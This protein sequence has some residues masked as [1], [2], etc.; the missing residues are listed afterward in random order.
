MSKSSKECQDPRGQPL[1]EL[2]GTGEVK[3]EVTRH[4]GESGDSRVDSSQE[5]KYT[6]K[7]ASAQGGRVER[8]K[9]D[10]KERVKVCL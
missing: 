6:G 1:E 7:G 4:P 3:R 2:E 8:L 9:G 10:P 5:G